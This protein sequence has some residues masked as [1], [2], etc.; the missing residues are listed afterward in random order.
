MG[1][2][3]DFYVGQG[4]TATWIG[5][6]A[7]DGYPDGINKTLL[8][9][10]TEEKFREEFAKFIGIREDATLPEK[11]WPWPWDNS[12]TTNYAYALFDGKVWASSF[13][14]QWFDPLKEEPEDQGGKEVQFP[15]MSSKKNVAHG[16]R[17]GLLGF[18]AKKQ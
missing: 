13:G 18:T 4:E 15:D 11:G 3:A 6:I 9:A 7:W 12:Q 1:T 5:S 8:K 16:E 10:K 17:S 2:R 14:H